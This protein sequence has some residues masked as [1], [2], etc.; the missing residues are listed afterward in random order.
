MLFTGSSCRVHE[1]KAKQ[2]TLY[3]KD[4]LESIAIDL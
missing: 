1:G 3:G 4:L 2:V